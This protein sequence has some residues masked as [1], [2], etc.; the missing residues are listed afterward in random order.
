[1][2]K[3]ILFCGLP[4]SGKSTLARKLVHCLK[5]PYFD[6]DDIRQR[7]FQNPR[8]EISR[9]KSLFQMSISYEALFLTTEML[10]ELG[11]DVVISAT[12][13]GERS[14]QNIIEISKRNNARLKA[15]YCHAP[16]EIIKKRLDQ[17]ENNKESFSTC[18]TWNHYVSDKERFKL[19]QVNPLLVID[20]SVPQEE[21][22]KRIIGF[23]KIN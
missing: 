14:Q 8:A 12:F 16:D 19:L 7:F 18:R 4:L 21:S 1:M 10:S 11:H 6:I 9:E 22:L 17:R 2:N 13:S 3:I 15:I 23:S 5:V 20:T